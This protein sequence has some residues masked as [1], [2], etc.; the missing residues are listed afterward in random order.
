MEKVP[1]YMQ[2]ENT[3]D[4]IFSE[5]SVDYTIPD[6]LPEVRKILRVSA[7]AIPS[8]K[9]V[10]GGTAEF[11]GI[12]AYTIVY[13]G[14]ESQ[15]AAVKFNSDYEFSV[16]M[17]S[18]EEELELSC[19]SA[20]DNVSCR[21][22]GPR[23]LSMR[24]KIKSSVHILSRD[25]LCEE[26]CGE[27]SVASVERKIEVAPSMITRFFSDDEISLSDIEN[28][29]GIKPDDL[30]I[31]YCNGEVLLRECRAT[32]DGILCR[33]EA[34]ARCVCAPDG[35][36]PF[37]LS[38]KFP[39]EKTVFTQGIDD[40]Y[41]VVARGM[42]TGLEVSSGSDGG[43]GT[44]LTF[45]IVISIECEATKNIELAYVSDIYSTERETICRERDVKIPRLAGCGMGN[46]SVDGSTPKDS[47]GAE[48]ASRII[49]C[50]GK[51]EIESIDCRR[52]RAIVCG[53]CVVSMLF[54]DAP[55]DDGSTSPIMSAEFSSP[56]KVE[57]DC[58]ISGG[59]KYDYECHGE[60]VN[61]RGRIDS[62]S[63]T[64]DGEI[65]LTVKAVA[66]YDHRVVDKAEF[67]SEAFAPSS[68]G[69]IRIYYPLKG[70]GL[71]DVAKRYHIH[72]ATLASVNNCHDTDGDFAHLTLEALSHVIIE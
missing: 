65:A 51:L 55:A 8:G 22:G 68:S 53:K 45:D 21:L 11:A 57:L 7:K 36:A 54:C 46:F 49:D 47:V 3:H 32:P 14:N 41:D 33:G 43:D 66:Y 35:I 71:W 39:F 27:A 56:F 62:T 50:E 19:Q 9:F 37:A 24:T 59:E 69:D 72:T 42:C 12:I 20:P 67:G 38:K 40:S 70:E 15:L 16:P 10:G 44:V 48:R 58:G 26:L 61:C 6:Y 31:L 29:S 64:F 18:P 52:G 25:N 30:R 13:S 63:I 17:S 5:S 2:R 34:Y 60:L 1:S 4:Y 23:R 28:V